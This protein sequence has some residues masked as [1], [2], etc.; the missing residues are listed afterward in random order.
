MYIPPSFTVTEQATLI[1]FLRENS[2][3]ILFSTLQGKPFASHLPLLIDES[4]GPH[5]ALLGHMAKANAQW[6]GLEGQEVLAVFHGPHALVESRFYEEDFMVPTWNYVAVHVTGHF[7]RIADSD[8]VKALIQRSLDTY[9][10]QAPASQRLD[11]P[12]FAAMLQAIVAFRI[13]ITQIE[14]KWKLSQNHPQARQVK[15]AQAL[16]Q[17]SD[18]QAQQIAKMMQRNLPS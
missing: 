6:D 9:E 11:E 4:H 15:V 8:A 14:G 5:G 17:S 1:S 2:F 13:D 16:A 3:A 7:H 10:P 12:A 18:S